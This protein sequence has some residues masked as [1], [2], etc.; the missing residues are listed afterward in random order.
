MV[1]KID[2]TVKKESMY[3]LTVTVILSVFMQGICLIV[4][5]L[6]DLKYSYTYITGNLV[7]ALAASLN[8]FLMGVTVQKAVNSDEKAAKEK[9][10]LSQS[11]RNAAMFLIIA[12]CVLLK[13]YFNL[14]TLIIPLFFPRIAITL[15]PFFN[16]GDENLGDGK[17]P[18]V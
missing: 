1:P 13:Q 3:I 10:R 7:S 4:C 14:V 9:I 16:K 8:F 18:E 15:R 17:K 5:A 2:K 11:L 12:L 6:S